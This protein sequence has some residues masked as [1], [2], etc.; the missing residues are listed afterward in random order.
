MYLVPRALNIVDDRN[1]DQ[2]ATMQQRCDY[3]QAHNRSA[4][5]DVC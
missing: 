2:L 5:G 1:M 3:Q 4:G